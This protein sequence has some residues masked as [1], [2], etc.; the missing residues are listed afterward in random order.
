MAALHTDMPLQSAC[1]AGIQQ[2]LPNNAW[3]RA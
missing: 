2:M 1:R 3:S